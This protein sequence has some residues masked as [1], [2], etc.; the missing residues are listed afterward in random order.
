M[1]TLGNAPGGPADLARLALCYPLGVALPALALQANAQDSL[2]HEWNDR[3]DPPT[4]VGYFVV[5]LNGKDR[6]VEVLAGFRQAPLVYLQ[7]G[8]LMLA[9]LV[10]EELR[11]GHKL[12]GAVQANLRS[13]A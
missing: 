11:Q 10:K 7:G 12:I 8:W 5:V 1:N 3:N 6:R 2:A 13:P 4:L 9:E